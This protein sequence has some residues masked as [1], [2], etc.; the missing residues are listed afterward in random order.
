MFHPMALQTALA[1][2]QVA[3]Q[4]VE[5]LSMVVG[6]RKAE[7]EETEN[8]LDIRRGALGETNHLLQT[9]R[10]QQAV[11]LVFPLTCFLFPASRPCFVV[12]SQVCFPDG[13]V[14]T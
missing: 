7:I 11:G 6:Q 4:K 8:E 5:Q 9:A 2:K 10:A 3:D 13:F 1:N 14:L 12:G